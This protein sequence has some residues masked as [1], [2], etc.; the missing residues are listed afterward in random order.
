MK[1]SIITPSY[2]QGKFIMQ[3]IDSVLNQNYPNLEYIVIDGGSTDSTINILKKYKN[4]VKWISEKDKGQA[5]AINKGIKMVT[6][7]IIG[8]LNS[9]DIYLPQALKTVDDFFKLNPKA[10]WAMGDYSIINAEGRKIRPY[11]VWYK[12]F[13]RPF[14]SYKLLTFT[15]YIVQPSTFWRKNV[16]KTIGLFDDSLPYEMDYDYWL[17]IAS[18]F[19]LYIIKKSLSLFRIHDSS[20]SGLHYLRQFEEEIK[21]LE[22]HNINKSIKLLHVIHNKIIIFLYNLMKTMNKNVYEK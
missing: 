7:D 13:L 21:V 22:K 12:R 15:N 10:Q 5:D 11:V 2:N 18:K 16:I 1:I 4:K 17:R 14:N 20:K 8:Y 6:G 19:P 3:T 9:D